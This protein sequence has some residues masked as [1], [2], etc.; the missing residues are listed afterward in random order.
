MKHVAGEQGEGV[1]AMAATLGLD[2]IDSIASC[3][4]VVDGQI[5]NRTFVN[6]GGS[7]QGLLVLAAGRGIKPADLEQVPADSDL[8]VGVSLDATRIV[9]TARTLAAVGGPASADQ[10]DRLL[11][12]I[13]TNIDAS[14]EENILQGFGNVMVF[15]D[16]PSAGGLLAT[17]LVGSVEVT[18]YDR[19][20]LAYTGLLDF[21]K[22]N[23]DV[24]RN[25]PQRKGQTL[26]K[27]NFLDETIWY[28]N[29]FGQRAA[30]FTPSFCMTKTHLYV[31]P[32]PQALKA[33]LRFLKSKEPNFSSKLGP[34]IPVNAGELI[35][36]GY[37]DTRSLVR[38]AY[39]LAP[40]FGQP[41]MSELQ[42]SGMKL[43]VYAIPSAKAILPF[44]SNAYSTV[45]RTRDGILFES[46]SPL[47]IP[48]GSAVLSALPFGASMFGIRAV[49]V[50]AAEMPPPELKPVRAAVSPSRFVLPRA[51]NS[52]TPQR[53]GVPLSRK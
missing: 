38:Y 37:A 46:Q 48:G 45:V 52:G 10:F 29:S 2:K 33:H 24:D 21:L 4:G 53:V 20:Y 6:T 35:G 22:S 5:R 34:E 47:P 43:D 13:E 27:A 7:T 14:V 51:A 11:Q 36:L 40:Y 23:M 18:D 49:R 30:P 44:L 12:E 8:V 28:I 41:L 31:A 3:V 26:E 15:H 16:S 25:G 9:E 32:H 1:A 50:G 39:A 42:R 17:S 19:A